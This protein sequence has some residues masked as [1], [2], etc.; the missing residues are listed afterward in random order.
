MS[1]DITHESDVSQECHKSYNV[2]FYMFQNADL[3]LGHR[4][5][6]K[7]LP[8]L[9]CFLT[10]CKKTKKSLLEQILKLCAETV[11]N[12]TWQ[13]VLRSNFFFDYLKFNRCLIFKESKAAS[14]KRLNFTFSSRSLITS[15]FSW[16][17]TRL[18]RILPDSDMSDNQFY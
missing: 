6:R 9:T 10:T 13:I 14:W 17:M 2:Q 11:E 5:A 1:S 4:S 7:C 12:K 15:Y 8:K 18:I 16:S 3:T